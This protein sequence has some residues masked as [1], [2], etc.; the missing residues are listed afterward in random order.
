MALVCRP[1][2]S[3]LILRAE[4]GPD[5]V[6]V[7]EDLGRGT[8]GDQ[9][10]EVQ[11]GGRRAAGRHEAHVVI[12]EDDEGAGLL[13]DPPDQLSQ[14]GGLLV[15]QAG[16]RLGLERPPQPPAGPLEVGDRQQV[17]AEGAD[18]ARGR[19]DEPAEHVEERGL[20]GAVGSDQAARAGGEVE[21]HRVDRHDAAEADG[22]VLHLDHRAISRRENSPPMR[23]PSFA[24]SFGTWST[25]P[26][27]AVISTCR[28]PTPNR[29]VSSSVETPQSSS[30]AG[31]I[32][33]RNAA[34]TA[35]HTLYTP[36]M[37]T[38][39]SSVTDVSTG[40][41]WTLTPPADAASRPPA[42]PA[43]NDARANA[44]S[45]YRTVFTPA[46]TA[47]A[48]LWRGAAHPRPGVGRAR[49]AAGRDMRGGGPPQEG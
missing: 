3:H 33:S 47:V 1:T 12:D 5:D 31:R 44:H 19:A 4:I 35:P 6:R 48:W 24:R 46:D 27:G 30:R 40:N 25:R 10:A 29:I 36:P 23:R 15:G 13:G 14:P 34:T 7:A 26:P 42:T 41:C 37:R 38:T 11:D 32:R 20:A 39:A 16:R 45:L 43:V 49:P 8:G 17:L 21:R 28:T 22:E 2:L 18:P 9:L